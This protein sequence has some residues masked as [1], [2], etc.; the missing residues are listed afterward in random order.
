MKRF[1]GGK[2]GWKRRR[3]R[4]RQRWKKKNKKDM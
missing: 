3:L 1:G 4:G 2:Q